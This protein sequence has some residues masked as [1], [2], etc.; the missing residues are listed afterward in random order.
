MGGGD[1]GVPSGDFGGVVGG[2]RMEMKLRISAD[3]VCQVQI[4]ER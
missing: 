4:A 2:G 3:L 1:L